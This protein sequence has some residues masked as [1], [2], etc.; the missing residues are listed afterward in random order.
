MPASSLTLMQPLRL[1]A[2]AATA[3]AVTAHLTGAGRADN[4]RTR[5]TSGGAERRARDGLPLPNSRRT[6]R[7][8]P[9]RP[10]DRATTRP[11][12]RATARPAARRP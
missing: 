6:A 3:S 12:D 8:T 4:W 5:G 11:T 2:E 7:D 10:T 9:T 1:P